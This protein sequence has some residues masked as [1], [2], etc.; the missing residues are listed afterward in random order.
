MRRRP[1]I[2]VDHTVN[3]RLNDAWMRRCPQAAVDHAVDN[4]LHDA[5]TATVRVNEGLLS[6]SL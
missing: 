1:S 2:A 5:W 6:E 3:D 4:R